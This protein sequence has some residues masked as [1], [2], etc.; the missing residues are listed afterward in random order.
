MP[1]RPNGEWS[2][3]FT[4]LDLGTRWK[5]AISFTPRPFYSWWGSLLYPLDRRPGGPQS[6]SR[7]CEEKSLAPAGNQTAAFIPQP[8]AIPTE[9]SHRQQRYQCWVT[10]SKQTTKQ[11][12]LLGN[13]KYAQLLTSNALA[14]KHVSTEI[15]GVQQLTVFSTRFVP[16]CYK[17]ITVRP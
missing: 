5:W 15:V 6:R 9:L 10:T 2:Y 16:R 7:R 11:H 14:N 12:P 1:W 17:Q 8:A 13:S 3:S 4:F